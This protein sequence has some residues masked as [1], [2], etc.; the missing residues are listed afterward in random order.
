MSDAPKGGRY[1]GPARFF[2]V[3]DK[4]L[5]QQH[6]G[7]ARMLLGYMR[8]H[9][10]IGGP[11]IQ[12]HY[13]RLQ[14][15]TEIKG[16]MMN[17]QFQAEIISPK[18]VAS[19]RGGLLFVLRPTTTL[20][21]PPAANSYAT[22]GTTD[23][24]IFLNP[25]SSFS[26]LPHGNWGNV[27]WYAGND[28]I[29]SYIR[30]QQDFA[31]HYVPSGEARYAPWLD[32]GLYL[33]QLQTY[34]AL[35]FDNNTPLS[36][37]PS[38]YLICGVTS[39]AGYVF[40]VAF[41]SLTTPTGKFRVFYGDTSLV[42]TA[43]T[44]G[45]YTM[46]GA[47]F[48][49]KFNRSGNEGVMVRMNVGPSATYIK[50]SL[51]GLVATF[52]EVVHN[53]AA[54][55]D[56]TTTLVNDYTADTIPL[57][58]PGF[59]YPTPGTYDTRY[60]HDTDQV[61]IVERLVA[62]DYFGDE[63]QLLVSHSERVVESRSLETTT[64]VI[65]A[66]NT[67]YGLR[68][69]DYTY[70]HDISIVDTTTLTYRLNGELLSTRTYISD[71]SGVVDTTKYSEKFYGFDPSL[72]TGHTDGTTTNTITYTGVAPEWFDLRTRVCL[73]QGYEDNYTIITVASSDYSSPTGDPINAT[74]SSTYSGN[75]VRTL[76]TQVA[77]QTA[78]T[79]A[80]LGTF[81]VDGSPIPDYALYVKGKTF[82]ADGVFSIRSTWAGNQLIAL[83]KGGPTDIT[84]KIPEAIAMIGLATN[85][86][87]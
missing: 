36:W 40:V 69:Y 41:D 79:A 76:K 16:V 63:L 33:S 21:T 3:G 29:L 48:S 71:V 65:T 22:G 43:G 34:S 55:S 81:V 80:A 19:K 83:C 61:V 47:D 28:R 45:T 10:A 70:H 84:A 2:L 39:H 13:T 6:I 26:V 86:T 72:L 15:G 59:V 75:V 42:G 52:T 5:A 66:V 30:P 49:M 35:V 58:P 68:G 85:H 62:A 64:T 11:E 51:T 31:G 23:T 54:D 1:F 44:S 20:A 24:D 87:P 46:G 78:Q 57:D 73:H 4:V 18:F 38:S 60:Q 17:G 67:A 25:C 53:I 14:D 77:F 37:V 12:A 50:V 82:D 32:P 56:V 9:L 27:D 8:D 7:E 74:G